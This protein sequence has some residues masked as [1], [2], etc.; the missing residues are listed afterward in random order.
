MTRQKPR[1]SSRSAARRYWDEHT[2]YTSAAFR[3]YALAIGQL[4]MAWNDLHSRLALLFCSVMGGGY[5]NQFL[6]IW[7]A[8]KADR[9]QR[10]ILLA[11][12]KK[13]YNS[14]RPVKFLE[15]IEWLCKKADEVEE[16]RNNALHSPLWAD[17]RNEGVP[18]VVPAT[19]LGHVR[20]QKLLGKDLL[21][22]FRWCRDAAI[23]LRV[24]AADIDATMSEFPTPWPDR[25]K[26][27]TRED[28]SGKK[29]RA[30]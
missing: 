25:P 17:R 7:H 14:A 16:A 15:D 26:W 24:F 23:T 28:V 8:L 22:E 2:Q 6:A 5:A 9:V 11:A 29:K 27:P 4:A 30:T 13:D 3:P 19:G 10:E 1:S 21:V 18:V 20:A 12:V